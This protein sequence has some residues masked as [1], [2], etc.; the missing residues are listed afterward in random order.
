[1]RDSGTGFSGFP[2]SRHPR[3]GA[4]L[5]LALVLLL[6]PAVRSEAFPPTVVLGLY[7][8]DLVSSSAGSPGENVAGLAA[9]A[10]LDWGAVFPGGGSVA[11]AGSTGWTF[12]PA[13]SYDREELELRLYLPAGGF[14][15]ELLSS[16]DASI[17]GAPDDPF[18]Y[19]Q[20]SW[21]ASL[22]WLGERS[23]IRP[24]AGLQGYVR[25]QRGDDEDALYQ[26]GSLGVE[27]VPSYLATYRVG[28]QGGW[29][30]FPEQMLPAGRRE[31]LLGLLECEGEWLLGYFASGKL[32]AQGGYRFSEDPTETRGFGRLEGA[33]SWSPRRQIDLQGS[34]FFLGEWYAARPLPVPQSGEVSVLS[35]GFDLGF[36]W[37]PDDRWYLVLGITGAGSFSDDPAERGWDFSFQAG[38]ELSL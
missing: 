4:F 23:R 33:V 21:S 18:P 9:G 26:G 16:L 36:D 13:A 11:V 34:A 19:L 15:L 6:F 24:F 37:T 35:A 7:G 32:S 27:V 2:G 30:R 12:A 20:P 5:S 28:F 29:Q 3:T 22:R 1:M 10:A 17:L 8:S 14:R 31:D 38:L 25:V